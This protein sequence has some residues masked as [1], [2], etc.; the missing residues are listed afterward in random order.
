MGVG[1]GVGAQVPAAFSWTPHD[2]DSHEVPPTANSRSRS[3][4]THQPRSWSKAEANQ[5]I[6]LMSV[7]LWTAQPPMSWSKASAC[8][9]MACMLVTPEVSHAPMFS[10]KEAAATL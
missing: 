3:P 4:S 6:W 7:T 5:N 2:V 9:N 8:L 1:A 10:L